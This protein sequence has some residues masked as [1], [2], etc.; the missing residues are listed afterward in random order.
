MINII[1]FTSVLLYSGI[2]M[3]SGKYDEYV[4]DDIEI[5]KLYYVINKEQFEFCESPYIKKSSIKY[6]TPIRIARIL[7]PLYIGTFGFYPIGIFA[8]LYYKETE[9]VLIPIWEQK[10]KNELCGYLTYCNRAKVP[11]LKVLKNTALGIT[12]NN[13]T[14]FYE[15]S[16]CNDR[17]LAMTQYANPPTSIDVITEALVHRLLR[18]LFCLKTIIILCFYVLFYIMVVKG[19]EEGG[20]KL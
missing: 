1:A 8:I 3:F 2:K 9:M 4:K 14:G 13:K 6:D 12:Y 19:Y 5:R 17:K 7:T 16:E 20:K 15:S 10:Y 18:D 11:M